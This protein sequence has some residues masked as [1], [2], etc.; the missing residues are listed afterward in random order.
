MHF[1]KIVFN[2][3]ERVNEE[4]RRRGKVVRIV[5]DDGSV[6]RFIGSLLIE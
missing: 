4:I 5:P 3:L 2:M 1:E 6:L